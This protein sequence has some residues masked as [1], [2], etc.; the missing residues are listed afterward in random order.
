M[1]QESEFTR[2]TALAVARRLEGFVK[3]GLG[4]VMHPDVF[5]VQKLYRR[6]SL[7][8]SALIAEARSAGYWTTPDDA[9]QPHRFT[10]FQPNMMCYP[11]AAV[12]NGVV[13]KVASIWRHL[14]PE[15][16]ERVWNLR[17][18][19]EPPV[20]FDDDPPIDTYLNVSAMYLTADIVPAAAAPID[21]DEPIE[22]TNAKRAR[23]PLPQDEVSAPEMPAPNVPVIAL[24]GAP[25]IPLPGTT[26]EEAYMAPLLFGPPPAVGSLPAVGRRSD[27]GTDS[28]PEYVEEEEEEEA[29]EDE[30]YEQPATSR[31]RAKNSGGSRRKRATPSTPSDGPTA[32]GLP[33]LTKEIVVEW[34]QREFETKQE[35]SSADIRAKFD[36][37][38]WDQYVHGQKRPGHT[39]NCIIQ[40]LELGT[41]FSKVKSGNSIHFVKGKPS[42]AAAAAAAPPKKTKKRTSTKRGSGKRE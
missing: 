13:T 19:A 10:Q 17:P 9:L 12:R 4:P 26:S 1:Q 16:L 35:I 14:S 30:E 31:K 7:P 6:E 18:R 8:L 24:A 42:A 39:V 23:L 11:I 3:N 37:G 27:D 36:T 22:V 28:N 25:L 15:L 38:N 33:K 5:V 29:S 21:D 40:R 34:M 41:G 20:V 2:E 32:S